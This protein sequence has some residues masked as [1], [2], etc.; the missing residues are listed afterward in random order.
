MKTK[1]IRVKA[2]MLLKMNY[3]VPSGAACECNRLPRHPAERVPHLSLDTAG[4]PLTSASFPR[5][6]GRNWVFS[7]SQGER[8]KF[9][10]SAPC[11]QPKIWVKTSATQRAMRGLIRAQQ[12]PAVEGR[13]PPRRAGRSQR[14]P[15]AQPKADSSPAR[16]DQ[17]DM[18]SRVR[19]GG[20]IDD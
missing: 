13:H 14:G 11:V 3:L 17:N 10:T 9:L 4:G 15:W 2:G 7:L 8:A 5:R 18:S 6:K 19:R 1:G 16:R 12:L 20:L